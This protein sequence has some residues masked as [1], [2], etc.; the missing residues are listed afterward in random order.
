MQVTVDATYRYKV[1][2]FSHIQVML[3]RYNV[4]FHTLTLAVKIRFACLRNCNKKHR[5]SPCE[6]ENK[7]DTEFAR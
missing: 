1:R 4:Q 2:I 5:I 6:L 3:K 7:F